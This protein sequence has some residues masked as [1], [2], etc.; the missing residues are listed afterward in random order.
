MA[1]GDGFHILATLP[2]NG[3]PSNQVVWGWAQ[4]LKYSYSAD[5]LDLFWEMTG[6]NHTQLISYSLTFMIFLSLSRQVLW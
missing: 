3:M 6:S 2:L 4:E 1:V 5:T